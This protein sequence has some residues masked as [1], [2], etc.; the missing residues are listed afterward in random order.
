[1]KGLKPMT[2][3]ERQADHRE[4]LL[5]NAGKRLSVTLS[6]EALASLEVI[7]KQLEHEEKPHT[8]KAAIETALIKVADHW[9]TPHP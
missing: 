8:K 6:R 7:Q 2:N 3:N 1:M 9:L 4:K 5:L